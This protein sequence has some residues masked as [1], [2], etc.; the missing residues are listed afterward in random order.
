VIRPLTG[1]TEVSKKI[2]ETGDL[3]QKIEIRSSGEIDTLRR[4]LES[5]VNKIKEEKEDRDNAIREL[6]NYKIHLEDLVVART[7]ELADAKEAA[8]SA[9]RTKSAF[10][11]TM[12]HE[13]RTP[14]N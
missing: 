8:E 4:S 9:D 2:A 11:A 1:L 10:L 7:K 3:D 12:S 5:M 13:L 14:L 6:E